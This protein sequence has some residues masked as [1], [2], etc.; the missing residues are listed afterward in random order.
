M[1]D[2][3]RGIGVSP[4]IAVAPV[5][6]MGAP[7]ESLPRAVTPDDPDAEAARATRA[8]DDVADALRQRGERASGPAEQILAAQSLMARDPALQTA[9]RRHIDGGLPAPHAVDAAIGEFREML[10]GAGAYMA[11]RVSDLDDIRNRAVARLLHLPVPGIP[12]RDAPFVLVADDLAPGDTVD[13]PGSGVVAL[14]TERGGTTSHT[15]IIAKAMGLPA[16][17]SCPGATALADGTVVIVDGGDGL[18]T[19]DPDA[20]QRATAAE[21]SAAREAMLR[22]SVGPGVT[23]DGHAVKL[24]VNFGGSSDIAAISADTEGVGLLRT[25]FLFLGR[26]EEP[27]G[28]EQETL[29][30]E[31]FDAFAGRKV[32]VRALDVGADKPLDFVDPGPG[33]NPALGLRGYRLGELNEGLVDRQ[34]QAIARAAKDS[35]AEVHVMAPMV[36][37][38]E[39][40][41]DFVQRT[42]AVGIDNAGVMIEIPALALQAERLFEVVDFA[43]LGT[44]DLSQYAFGADR[45]IGELAHLLDPWQPALLHLVA[46]A[47]RAGVAA[48]KPI[49]VCGEAASDPLLALVFAGLGVSS[50]SMAPTSIPEVRASLRSR[51][52]AQ[53]K[54][55]AAAALAATSPDGA[56]EAVGAALA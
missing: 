7:I 50:L 4:G 43:S 13:L 52:Y 53:C 15:A 21:Q 56:R 16:I 18:V 24:L 32:V 8:L 14:L 39:E 46:V 37:T 48:G 49:S 28:D 33:E 54:A 45:L 10:L 27:S 29:Y 17:V 11:D 9:I 12:Q 20:D 2:E 3:L 55:A 1:G 44:N 40:A 34:L 26:T 25:E 35:P 30:R 5:V 19:T 42:H 41:A 38:V 36:A 23:A 31:V 6:Q 51:T 22:G 47:I